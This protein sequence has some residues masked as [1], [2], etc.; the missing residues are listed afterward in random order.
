MHVDFVLYINHVLV[1]LVSI[2]LLSLPLPKILFDLQ[3][4]DWFPERIEITVPCVLGK[5]A[6]QLHVRVAELAS[7]RCGC[8]LL[9][10]TKFCLAAA[11]Y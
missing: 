10:L 9:C 6:H 5:V 7:A 8:V 3:E 11:S 2:L 4:L 1:R